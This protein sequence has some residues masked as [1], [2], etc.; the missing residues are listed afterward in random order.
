MNSRITLLLLFFLLKHIDGFRVTTLR[1]SSLLSKTFFG[2]KSPSDGT[3]LDV[4]DKTLNYSLEDGTFKAMMDKDGDGKVSAGDL[5]K[6]YGLAY[7]LTSISLSIASYATCYTLISQ[8]VDVAALL[9]KVGIHASENANTA[10]TAAV[11]YAVHKAA[12]PI[13]FPPTVALTPVVARWIGK[14]PDAS[15][16]DEE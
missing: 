10:G 2:T 5:F 11:A 12:S 1:R 4:E 9:Q 6:K 8:G 13:R 7:L 16:E 15:T 14:D 3:D